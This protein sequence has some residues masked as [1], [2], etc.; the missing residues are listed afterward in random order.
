MSLTTAIRLIK[1]DASFNIAGGMSCLKDL[2]ASDFISQA[3]T[4]SVGFYST[5]TVDNSSGIIWKNSY[6]MGLQRNTT[7]SSLRMGINVASRNGGFKASAF[8]G[9]T[10]TDVN[11][12]PFYFAYAKTGAG[13]SLSNVISFYASNVVVANNIECSGGM[14]VSQNMN[15]GGNVSITNNITS[16]TPL[17]VKDGLN[18][19]TISQNGTELTLTSTGNKVA[20]A[21]NNQ[22]V[23]KGTTE[24]YQL[25]A[26]TG[27]QVMD[28]VYTHTYISDYDIEKQTIDASGSLFRISTGILYF[29]CIGTLCKGQIVRGCFCFCQ[30]NFG[31]INSGNFG[32]YISGTGE[33]VEASQKNISLFNGWNYI[34]FKNTY[35]VPTTQNYHVCI[36]ILDTFNLNSLDVYSFNSVYLNY[37]YDLSTTKLDKNSQ[38]STSTNAN[39]PSNAN[40]ISF[41]I[42]TS[43]IFCG[44]WKN[45]RLNQDDS[46][47]YYFP[48]DNNYSKNYNKYYVDGST[49]DVPHTVING[50]GGTHPKVYPEYRRVGPASLGFST[51]GV[52]YYNEVTLNVDYFSFSFWAYST[53]T[54]T[55]YL[56]RFVNISRSDGGYIVIQTTNSNRI[57]RLQADGTIYV[58]Q[59]GF[60]VSQAYNNTW[61]HLAVVINGTK[62]YL[63]RNGLLH[64]TYD[65]TIVGGTSPFTLIIGSIS[66]SDT[67]GNPSYIDDFR[68]YNRVLSIDEIKSIYLYR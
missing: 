10:N 52:N 31:N 51:S 56:Q 9:N 24:T 55:D 7:N 50:S 46:L 22:V 53:N 11:N 13:E 49:T 66:S 44:V 45:F 3:T 33:L 6:N 12:P 32:L 27:R 40:G 54:S 62:Q 30:L 59:D 17:I 18:Q 48:F 25:S 20:I 39:L 5:S 43:N 68:L 26:Y 28:N 37:G 8:I 47:V 63:Y 19:G 57:Y 58:Q 61:V 15:V 36:L 34:Q 21:S 41:N 4:S 64:K 38:L 60:A 42:N 14:G 35:V 23:F 65:R 2:Y 29:S 1:I 16:S 67:Q